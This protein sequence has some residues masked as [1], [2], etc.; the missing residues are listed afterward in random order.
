MSQS[1]PA[2]GVPLPGNVSGAQRSRAQSLEID[3]FRMHDWVIRMVTSVFSPQ[4]L[5]FFDTALVLI[6]GW[7]FVT[8]AMLH[9]VFVEHELD[10]LGPMNTSNCLVNEVMTELNRCAEASGAEPEVVIVKMRGVWSRL[11][12]E[13]ASRL[14]AGSGLVESILE[15][16]SFMF[17]HERGF[18]LLNKEVRDA[19]GVVDCAF[20]LDLGCFGSQY[21]M[22]V[23][24]NFIGHDTVMVNTFMRINT[25]GDGDG[26][27]DR[28]GFLFSEWS[29]KVVDVSERRAVTGQEHA[30]AEGMKRIW[31]AMVI[32]MLY[33]VSTTFT[34]RALC[35]S[36]NRTMLLSLGIQQRLKRGLPYLLFFVHHILGILVFIPLL[37]G[38]LFSFV[39]IYQDHFLTFMVLTAVWL[40]EL[41]SV[42]ALRSEASSRG[43]PRN[44]FIFFVSFHVYF[45]SYPSGFVF[46]AAAVM[47]MLQLHSILWYWNRYEIDALRSGR[48]HAKCT[49]E[50]RVN[51]E[52]DIPFPSLAT[53]FILGVKKTQQKPMPRTTTL[54]RMSAGEQAVLMRPKSKK[55]VTLRSPPLDT[56][57]LF[58]FKGM[59]TQ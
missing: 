28:D 22:Y 16:P 59:K 5:R 8:L 14:Y 45:F 49:Q 34:N 56:E 37:L 40:C 13:A 18:L 3:F 33:L 27:G 15:D 58:A 36:Q 21:L 25:F 43:F 48:I 12:P 11:E 51:T 35:E 6:A 31:T 9:I 24:D 53:R 54:G 23:L 26:D 32:G 1:V 2:A 57:E 7:T 44:F 30:V 29:K 20:H 52:I 4:A 55:R 47:I 39:T 50:T 19:H 17:A 42:V 38:M 10:H 46:L 41:V